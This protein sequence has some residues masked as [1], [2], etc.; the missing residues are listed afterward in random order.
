MYAI[1]S[2]RARAAVVLA[3]ALGVIAPVSRLAAQTA[4]ATVRV[5]H[6]IPG[7]DVAATLDPQLPVDVKVNDSLC[8]LQ[9]FTFGSVSRPLTLPVGSYNVKVSLAN[10]IT[11]CGNAPV[12]NQTV[13]VTAGEEAAVVAALSPAGAPVAYAFALDLSPI[14]KGSGRVIVA[15]AADAS[16]VAV[17]VD[18]VRAIKDLAPGHAAVATLRAKTYEVTVFRAGK[19]NPLVGPLP[20]SVQDR[21]ATLVFAVGSASSGSITLVAAPIPGVF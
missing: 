13:A 21:T 10:P 11:P 6:G 12:I 19:P 17:A 5:V 4:S 8:I 2:G 14:A 1:L 9:G 3:C 20:L 18:G 15:H 16:P 7:R